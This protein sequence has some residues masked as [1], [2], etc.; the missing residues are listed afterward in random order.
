MCVPA[1]CRIVCFEDITSATSYWIKGRNFSIGSLLGD[2]DRDEYYRGG[3]IVICRLAPQDYHRFHSPAAGRVVGVKY[4]HGEYYTVNPVA[5]R[6]ELDVLTEN[7][8]VL[9]YIDTEYFGQIAYVAVGA[10]LVGSI[11]MTVDEGSVLNA[12]DEVG[13]FAFGGSTIVLLFRSNTVVLDRDL[14]TSSEEGIET[15]VQVGMSL[16]KLLNAS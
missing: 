12:M 7:K 3:S 13:Y 9:F 1:D 4:C 6:E 8:R 14:L 5:V 11:R 2:A 10:T 16:G 15:L